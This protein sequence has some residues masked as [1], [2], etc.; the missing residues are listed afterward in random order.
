MKRICFYLI[1]SLFVYTASSQNQD[2]FNC[3][4]KKIGIT[5]FVKGYPHLEK[6]NKDS[7]LNGFSLALSDNSYKIIGFKILYEFPGDPFGEKIIM[8]DKITPKTSLFFLI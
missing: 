7:L 4:D 8:G 5:G 6:I 3:A 1:T 2:S